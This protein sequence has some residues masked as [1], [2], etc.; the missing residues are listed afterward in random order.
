LLVDDECG[1]LGIAAGRDVGIGVAGE[2]RADP[3][4]GKGGSEGKKGVC[5]VPDP[6]RLDGELL[7]GQ[8]EGIDPAAVGESLGVHGPS[9]VGKPFPGNG[10]GTGVAAPVVGGIRSE[11]L[12]PVVAA[13]F[14]GTNPEMVS[15]SD[16]A[17]KPPVGPVFGGTN[18][19]TVSASVVAG[20][21]LGN[22]VVPTVLGR[23]PVG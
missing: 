15:P 14:G 6:T 16:T 10:L 17:E 11:R 7:G 13:L 22:I 8:P 18:P 5:E 21:E 9:V 23:L 3:L 1:G 4:L 12:R 20:K 2:A 19:E